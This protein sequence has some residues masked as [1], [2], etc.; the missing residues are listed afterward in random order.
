MPMELQCGSLEN[1][2]CTVLKYK[3]KDVNVLI[4]KKKV[5]QYE[6]VLTEKMNVM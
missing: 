1:L 6:V 5:W 4:L 3:K 2:T